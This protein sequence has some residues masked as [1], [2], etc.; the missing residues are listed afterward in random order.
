MVVVDG[1]G[2][3]ETGQQAR[4]ICSAG[5][6]PSVT[7]STL[8]GATLLSERLDNELGR[9]SSEIG[10][11]AQSGRVPLGYLGDPDRSA[12]TFP[13]VEGRR[14]AVPGD[15]A[16]WHPDG[17]LELL[18]RESSTINSGGEKVFAEEVEGALLHHRAVA[19]CVVVGRPSARWG[20]EV[21]AIVALIE[22]AQAADADLL[23]EAARHL[24]R[25][26][27][28]KSILRVDRVQ[29]SA[30]GK[31][32]YHWAT[33]V[34]SRSRRAEQRRT[35]QLRGSASAHRSCRHP[36]LGNER[37]GLFERREVTAARR[38]ARSGAGRGTAVRAIA[39][40]VG[41]AHAGTP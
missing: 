37:V 24:A 33:Q 3:S 38:D 19:D 32:D 30:A 18:G 36:Q 35:E 14:F 13:V 41:R 29:R 39:A 21:V 34:G 7:F 23:E 27:L 17:R 8:T 11:L 6:D 5:Q 2:A 15:R 25:Y 20:Q 28:P 16:R 10:W 40:R 9:E 22:G 26:K 31:A 4:R 1:L 12:R